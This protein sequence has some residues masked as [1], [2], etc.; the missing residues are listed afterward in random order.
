MTNPPAATSHSHAT[1][2]QLLAALAPA[3]DTAFSAAD[4]Q[5]GC[6][7]DQTLGQYVDMLERNG[8]G[9]AEG[10]FSLTGGCDAYPAAPIPV[11]LLP[12]AG[13][14]Y[15]RVIADVD[16][17]GDSPWHYELRFRRRLTDGTVDLQAFSCPGGA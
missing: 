11:D 6:P 3:A 4:Q 8:R 10:E 15:C 2:D 5:R 7:A 9:E 14:E 17:G 12:T 13:T 16:P 1:V